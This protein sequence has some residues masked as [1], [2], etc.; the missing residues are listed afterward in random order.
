MHNSRHI[1]HLLRK[2]SRPGGFSLSVIRPIA[3]TLLVCLLTQDAF[4]FAPQRPPAP[5]A[6]MP[7]MRF[8]LPEPVAMV[9]DGFA[10]AAEAARPPRVILF[11][12]AHTNA[13]GQFNLADALER[14][15]RAE[16]VRRVY[17]EGGWGDCSLVELKRASDPERLRAAAERSV[18]NGVLHGE[19]FL[20]LTSDLDLEI[21]GAENEA[22][23]RRGLEAYASA[24]RSR[25]EA[26]RYLDRMRRGLSDQEAFVLN[27]ELAK[28][29]TARERYHEGDAAFAEWFRTLL[30]QARRTGVYLGAY[31]HLK[32]ARRVS[33]MER[34][35]DPKRIEREESAAI[36]TL[37]DADRQAIEAA[38]PAA[39]SGGRAEAREEALARSWYF[40]L[41]EKLGREARAYPALNR[42]VRYLREMRKVSAPAVLKELEALESAVLD[43]SAADPLEKLLIRLKDSAALLEKLVRLR[44]TPEEYDRL[45]RLQGF[46]DAEHLSGFVNARI[47]E[48]ESGYEG[49][50]LLKK[51]LEDAE[52][53]AK[54]FYAAAAER[55]TLFLS[56]VQRHL[57]EGLSGPAVLITGG[58]HTAAL[59]DRLRQ[60]GISFVSILPA[61][62]EETDT[63]RYERLLLTQ[64][65]RPEEKESRPRLAND[66]PSGAAGQR[67][68]P[69]A[70]NPVEL[71]RLTAAAIPTGLPAAARMADAPERIRTAVVP[72]ESYDV[73]MTR[74]VFDPA[75][76]LLADEIRGRKT[77]FVIDRGM[78]LENIEQFKKY[79]FAKDLTD[80][81]FSNV[82]FVSGGE[83]LKNGLRGLLRVIW[84][85]YKAWKAGL[86][87]KS[88]FVLAGGGATL[89]MAGFAAS[90]LTSAWPYVS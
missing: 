18:R 88:V 39:G 34:S 70:L 36:R 20:G 82:L 71:A 53:A 24:A 25:D 5:A 67:T 11:Q 9:D 72:D 63:A 90:V 81:A 30:G 78:G 41:A 16:G 73:V 59:K 55:D 61:V 49:A 89:D 29:Q 27:P 66:L 42:Y 45:T 54:R 6:V 2:A 28:F 22:A 52:A 50:I 68:L 58:F 79:L 62:T 31:P 87:R 21:V 47:L 69:L 44:I 80:P 77:F 40:L 51:S 43:R 85:N 1:N 13:S 17:V 57:D 3:A 84:I 32:F 10:P 86:D 64:R 12:D 19:E 35:L 46:A 76:P 4:A 74:G 7:L 60:Q 26:L 23:Y 8:T 33:A 14:V 75:N 56:S 15:V 37:S 83:R 38:R 65:V 48:R